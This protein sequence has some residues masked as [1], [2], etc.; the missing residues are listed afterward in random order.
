M[1]EITWRISE[2]TGWN[3]IIISTPSLSI[4]FSKTSTSSSSAIARLHR[5]LSRFKRP[6]IAFSS[7]RSA[8]LDIIRA[9]FFR[10]L[11]AASKLVLICLPRSSMPMRINAM[12]LRFASGRS[13]FFREPESPIS[14][15]RF[16]KLERKHRRAL[17]GSREPQALPTTPG[18]IHKIHEILRLTRKGTSLGCLA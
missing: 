8:R 1:V 12:S 16:A 7:N 9:S 14:R 10:L 17:I 5:V 2:A 15:V 6:C 18:R 3:R 11:S 4:C 13:T